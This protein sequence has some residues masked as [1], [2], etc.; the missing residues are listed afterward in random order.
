MVFDNLTQNGVMA[1]KLSDKMEDSNTIGSYLMRRK[2]ELS[3][4]VLPTFTE[5]KLLPC[6]S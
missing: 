1:R 6:N 5:I 4:I 2:W 3:K